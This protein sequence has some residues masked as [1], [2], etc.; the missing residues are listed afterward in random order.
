MPTTTDPSDNS[1]ERHQRSRLE[2]EIEEILERAER[3]NPLPPPLPFEKPRRNPTED[4]FRSTQLRNMGSSAR[5]WLIAAPL[6]T[7]YM[8][9]ILAIL[10]SGVS[11]LLA[12]L[13][14]SLAVIAV[15]W[16]ILE[17]YRNRQA[18][19]AP[20]RMWRGRDMSAP[21][22]TRIGPSPW[23]QFRQWLRNHRLLP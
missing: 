15:F 10:L 3:D 9:A 16:P 22:P 13:A 11:P 12:R 17:H 19:S 6:I 21:P 14:V 20:S 8:F 2:A 7:A 1:G 23:E 5:Q 4:A 18:S